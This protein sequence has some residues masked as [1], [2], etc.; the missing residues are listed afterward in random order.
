M[1]RDLAEI[2]LAA[3]DRS[4]FALFLDF[5]G[6][7]V[8]LAERPAEV[9]LVPGLRRAL[10]RIHDKLSGALAVV[11]GRDIRDVD[12]FLDPLRLPVAGVHGLTRRDAQGQARDVPVDKAAPDLIAARLAPLA[13]AHDD[14]HLERKTGSVALHYRLSPD[15]EEECIAAMEAA[16]AD[17]SGIHLLRGKMVVEARPKGAG[18]GRAVADFL[19]EAPFAG[20][21]PMFAGDDATDEDAFREVNKRGGLTVK[22]GLGDTA[23]HY[24]ASNSAE[25]Q[26]WLIGLADELEAREAARERA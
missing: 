1:T 12:G 4:D 24:R 15:L 8:D 10:G 13:E 14:I 5:D 23:A 3:I 17:L 2:S 6:T 25:F 7:V 22:I 26:A 18:K 11:T 19:D 20:R 16:T 9:V 21:T